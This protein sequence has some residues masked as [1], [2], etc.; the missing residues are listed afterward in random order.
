MH[1]KWPILAL[2]LVAVIIGGCSKS[3]P[4]DTSSKYPSKPITLI[5]QYA[6]GGSADFVARSMEKAA[7]KYLGQSLAVVNK[8]GGG[9]TLAYNELAETNPDGYTLGMVGNGVILQPLYTSTRY[10][11]STA[12]EPIAQIAVSPVVVAVKADSP[13]QTIDDFIAYARQHP[14]EVK[15]GHPGLGSPP[16]IVGEMLA[17]EAGI[18]ME[19]VPFLGSS[20]SAAATLGGHIQLLFAS[21]PSD[22]KELIRSGKLRALAVS[23]EKRLSQPEFANV[24]TLKERGL[25][26]AFTVWHGVAAPKS[27]PEDIKNKLA[28]GFEKI[29]NDPEFI[30]NLESMGLTVEYLGPKE[31]TEKWIAENK[32]MNAIVKESGIAELIASQK[33]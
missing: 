21:G 29:A 16:H 13:W 20:E 28:Q 32:Q 7:K 5:V 33:K 19:Q 31:S 30:N 26:V 23:G 12:L 14:S 3:T 1:H 25:D 10:H 9:G 8:P 24:P 15:F 11:Y 4:A 27:L 2:L 18:K 6:P 22:V 17:K